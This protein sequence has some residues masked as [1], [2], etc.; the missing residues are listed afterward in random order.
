MS[1]RLKLRNTMAEPTPGWF[2]RMPEDDH[3]LKANTYKHL[4]DAAKEYRR[5][6]N[7]PIGQQFE[8]D[9]QSWMCLDLDEKWCEPVERYR[10]ETATPLQKATR[11]ARALARWAKEGFPVVSDE[12]REE[13]MSACNA[14]PLY[15]LDGNAGMGQCTAPGCGCTKL[16]LWLETSACNHPGGSRWKR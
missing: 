5:A 8:A 1:E 4:V 2:V 7:Y 15:K 9:L 11:L 16:K 14:C 12:V 3:L 13:R 10:S 6:K